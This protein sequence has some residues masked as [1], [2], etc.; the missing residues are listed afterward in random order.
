MIKRPR[1][2][3]N[4]YREYVEWLGVQVIVHRE[5]DGRSYEGHG[6]L[7]DH[8]GEHRQLDIRVRANNRTFFNS[9]IWQ[10]SYYGFRHVDHAE[11]FVDEFKGEI[12]FQ[13]NAWTV[14][15]DTATDCFEMHLDAD[16]AA[17]LLPDWRKL[18]TDQFG[19]D[20][21]QVWG[22]QA[23]P[24]HRWKSPIQSILLKDERTCFAARM[25]LDHVASGEQF[26]G[27]AKHRRITSRS[28]VVRP[29]T[30]PKSEP[31][32]SPDR[33]PVLFA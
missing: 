20:A 31:G 30:W 29:P 9:L 25:F 33:M 12:I 17:Q 27:R 1:L 19:S 28:M 4:N 2:Y 15:S 14:E 5:R 26:E 22:F 21:W 3:L 32:W 16:R 7:W 24:N 18:L 23:Q 13:S 11:Q 8:F 6:W 10:Q